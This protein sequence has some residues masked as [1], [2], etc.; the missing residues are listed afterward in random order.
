MGA[1]ARSPPHTCPARL[2]CCWPGSLSDP[3]GWPH[4]GDRPPTSNPGSP[5]PPPHTRAL[6]AGAGGWGWPH[7]H[8]SRWGHPA[9]GGQRTCGAPAVGLGGQGGVSTPVAGPQRGPPALTYRS[10]SE[11]R[12]SSRRRSSHTARTSCP[13]TSSPPAPAGVGTAVGWAGRGTGPR[14]PPGAT[15]TR[16]RGTE[17]PHRGGPRPARPAPHWGSPFSLACPQAPGKPRLPSPPPAPC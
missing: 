11:T 9:S 6:P 13:C 17:A 2:G 1:K 12:W 15:H 8:R 3:M 10:R 4:P 16:S 14:G 5:A 7:R